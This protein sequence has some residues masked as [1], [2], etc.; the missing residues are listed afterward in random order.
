MEKH[1]IRISPMNRMSILLA[2]FLAM[3]FSEPAIAKIYKW[4]DDNGKI[5]F[6]DAPPNKESAEELDEQKLT[7]RIVSYTQVK[8]KFVPNQDSNPLYNPKLTKAFW[9]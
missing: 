3:I 8:V 2:I 1:N 7:K 6:T 9:R 5:H 4:T